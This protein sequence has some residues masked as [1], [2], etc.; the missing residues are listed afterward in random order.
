VQLFV[1]RDSLFVFVETSKIIQY[2]FTPPPSNPLQY[3][4]PPSVGSVTVSCTERVNPSGLPT[5]LQYILLTVGPSIPETVVISG[6]DKLTH[7]VSSS[8]LLPHPL[9]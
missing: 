5:E 2:F 9:L 1:L 3:S 4:F 8:G 6:V 7:I